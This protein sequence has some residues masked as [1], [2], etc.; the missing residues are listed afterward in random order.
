MSNNSVLQRKYCK[1]VGP[2]PR[3]PIFGLRSWTLGPFQDGREQTTGTCGVSAH[4]KSR[5]ASQRRRDPCHPVSERHLTNLLKSDYKLTSDENNFKS[6]TSINHIRHEVVTDTH[7]NEP[8]NKICIDL[9]KKSQ[10][11]TDI[12]TRSSEVWVQISSLICSSEVGR[13]FEPGH[14]V[15]L[16]GRFRDKI[17]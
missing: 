7:G 11:P 15:S 8:S 10:C 9:F 14:V 3:S 16:L 5:H 17:C 4:V 6:F 12:F 2:T 1:Y 13:G